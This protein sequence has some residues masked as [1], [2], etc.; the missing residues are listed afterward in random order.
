MTYDWRR[1]ALFEDL[2]PEWF[3][4]QDRRSAAVHAHFATD[5]IPFDR[6][7]PY[8]DLAGKKVL[9]IGVGAG[10]H[11]ELLVHAGASV[12]GIDLAEAA[13]AQARARFALRGLEGSFERRDAEEPNA[14]FERRFDFIWSWGVVHHSSR[15]ARIVRNVSSWLRDDGTFGGMVYHRDSL[16]ALASVMREWILRLRLFRES[17]D[18]ALWRSSDG[19]SARFYPA[20]QWR[21]LLLG[22]FEE[23][24]VRVSGQESDVL[25]LPRAFR[26]RILPRIPQALRS[27]VLQRAGTF[28]L[29]D[30]SRPLR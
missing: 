26:V 21:D 4:E 23:A 28:I 7:I 10:F 11:S 13:I 29:F 6:L 19:F 18:E 1:E 5:T 24:S 27:Q 8:A 30:A 15:T 12:T 9:E 17:V 22:F 2:T 25:P 14:A 16:V 20:D 3:E